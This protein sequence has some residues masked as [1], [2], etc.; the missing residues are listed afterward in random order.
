MKA[1]TLVFC[2][3]CEGAFKT[4]D[5]AAR[6]ACPFCGFAHVVNITRAGMSGTQRTADSTGDT[7][8]ATGITV[9]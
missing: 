1:Q 5:N 4:P 2:S 8:A 3:R 6:A 9:T 7:S